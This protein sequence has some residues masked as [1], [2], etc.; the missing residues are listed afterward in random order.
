MDPQDC[1]SLDSPADMYGF[2]DWS[3]PC[4]ALYQLH[5]YTLGVAD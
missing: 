3:F 5:P 1:L 2:A 4:S